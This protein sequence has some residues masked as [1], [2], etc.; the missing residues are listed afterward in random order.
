VRCSSEPSAMGGD[1]RGRRF[2]RYGRRAWSHASGKPAESRREGD[3]FG[4]PAQSESLP[5]RER[6]ASPSSQRQ[7]SPGGTRQPVSSLREGA[8]AIEPRAHGLGG[9]DDA[10]RLQRR[11]AQGSSPAHGTP[12]GGGKG[13]GDGEGGGRAGGRG[14]GEGA[15]S[16]P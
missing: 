16:K 13:S 5:A 7:G 1:E 15:A 4:A 2:V 6:C 12:E 11:R 10:R 14:A 9:K 3:P 8:A